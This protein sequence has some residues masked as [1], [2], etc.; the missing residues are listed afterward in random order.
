[1]FLR[2]T[3]TK[4]ILRLSPTWCYYNYYEA[5][6]SKTCLKG[7]SQK[8]QKWVFKTN[9]RLMQVKSIAEC[10]K[11]SILQYFRPALK[12]NL[13]LRPLFCLYLSGR[14][15]PVSLY[16]VSDSPTDRIASPVKEPTTQR[17]DDRQPPPLQLEERQRPDWLQE[18][19]GMYNNKWAAT[20]KNQQ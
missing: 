17:Q 18:E 14:L 2:L 3:S 12:Y 16:H 15:R 8:D 6:Y 19:K 10:S 5:L 11:G 1:M 20:C 4:F 13:A 7:H 9:Y